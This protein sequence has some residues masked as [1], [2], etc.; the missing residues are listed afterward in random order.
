MRIKIDM[1]ARSIV[2]VSGEN[3]IEKQRNLS[4]LLLRGGIENL[5]DRISD[6]NLFDKAGKPVGYK[7][8]IAGEYVAEAD[9]A[10]WSYKIN[11]APLKNQSAAAHI[12]WVSANSGIFMLDD[13][14]PQFGTKN[15]KV[16]AKIAFELPP[17]W[18]ISSGEKTLAL[19]V[20]KTSDV[21]K[22]V[23]L[24]GKL[25]RQRE[26]QLDG[27]KINLVT[28]DEWLF[29]ENEAAETARE[30]C[31]QYRNLFGSDPSNLAQII[32]AKFPVPVNPGIWQAETRG[33]NI[34]I[35]S[36]DMPFKAQSLQ[37]LHEQFRHEIF[38]LWLPNG[39][40]L[41]GN[42][43][44]FYE[45]FALYESL[46]TGVMLNQIRF[47]DFLDTLSRAHNIDGI[48]PRRMSL[49]EASKNRWSGSDTNVYARGMLV[50]FLCDLAL[51]E[52][53]KGRKSVR[54]IFRYIFE[55][56]RFPNQRQDGNAAVIE[57]LKTHGE[58][59]PIIEKYIKAGEKID[60]QNE[61]EVAG[62]ENEP[63]ISR[64]NL[65]VKEKLNGRQKALLEKLGYNNW[66]NLYRKSK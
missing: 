46:K 30:I 16:S 44:W 62:I 5:A 24:G 15:R 49:I 38:H 33:R 13:L 52:K 53:S 21:E 8:F 36:S 20:L 12:S 42:Y 63:G 60:W 45:G 9:F 2:H 58:L 26:I 1:Q 3:T 59:V 35:I 6:L 32:I 19:N 37:R 54:D 31:K 17:L 47:L 50:A 61:L 51:L 25:L 11:L 34:T 27:F 56:H 48:Q 23:I 7:K 64:T 55:K 28:N 57:A 29:T 22:T 4:F 40:N 41:S 18:E 14:L 10:A 43:D 66:R 39:V 65:R